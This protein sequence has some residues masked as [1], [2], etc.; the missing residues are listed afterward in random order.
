MAQLSAP[1]VEII[2]K[3]PIQGSSDR[4]S[5]PA[6]VEVQGF[7]G[8]FLTEHKGEAKSEN[9]VCNA[10]RVVRSS[11]CFWLGGH[12]WYYTSFGMIGRNC[13][14]NVTTVSRTFLVPMFSVCNPVNLLS[15]LQQQ[16]INLL[17]PSLKWELIGGNYMCG[18]TLRTKTKLFK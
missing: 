14:R 1:C 2:A 16:Q 17:L 10:L 5:A 6:F 18:R 15:I 3:Q 7:D 13:P 12:G 11:L 9:R 8:M 4:L